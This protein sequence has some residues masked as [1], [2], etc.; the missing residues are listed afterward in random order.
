MDAKRRF[1]SDPGPSFT[2]LTVDEVLSLHED[3]INTWGGTHGQPS[4][5]LWSYG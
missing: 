4:I 5:R 1:P 3:A 2:F